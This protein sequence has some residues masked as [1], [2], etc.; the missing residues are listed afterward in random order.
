[1]SDD[2]GRPSL[3]GS[4]SLLDA[5]G[6]TP[7][8]R[9][10]RITQEL[11][12][13][14]EVYVKAEWFNPGGSVKD[15]PVRQIVLDAE[16]DRRLGPDQTIL[17]SSSGNAGIAYAMIG[18]A[19]GYRVHL[20]VPGNVSEERKHILRAYGAQVE[21]SDPLEGSDGA[22]LVARRLSERGPDRYFYAD[23]YNN[24]SNPRAHYETTGPEIFAQTAG[25]I[26]H[27]VAGLGTSGTIVGAGRCLRELV[28]TVTVV[29]VEP[30]SGLHGIEGLKHMGSA[31]VPGIYDPSVHQRKISVRTETA[32]AL[33]RRLAREEGLLVGQSSGA[34]VAGALEVARD[35]REGVI[36]VVCPD[37]GDRYVSTALWR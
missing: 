15:R 32:Y 1:M 30:D 35:L 17:D 20:V 16:R 10:T 36:V 7:L 27:F 12:Q 21:Y 3:G 11:P 13:R 23:Q 25:H 26:T 22:I 4:S 37:G 9:L 31:I 6:N 34:A 18:A 5:I 33:A 24:P 8:L 29:A 19:R 14:V 2:H 28:P